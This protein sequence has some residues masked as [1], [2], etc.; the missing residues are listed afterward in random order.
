M[1]DTRGRRDD[2]LPASPV[3]RH[4][5]VPD[6][7]AVS[8][9]QG[10]RAT[11]PRRGPGAPPREWPGPV[12]RRL[13]DPLPDGYAPRFGRRARA[14][15]AEQAR[16]AEHAAHERAAREQTVQEQAARARRTARTGPGPAPQPRARPR[17]DDRSGPPSAPGPGTTVRVS[18][19]AGA[20]GDAAPGRSTWDDRDERA[21]DE[22]ELDP[23]LDPALEPELEAE[24][25]PALTPDVAGPLRGPEPAPLAAVR[26]KLGKALVPGE[27]VLVAQTRHPVVLAE[28]VLTSLLV[29][30]GIAAVSP[31]LG[32]MD[33][34]RNVLMAGWVAL[35]VRAL[36]AW[37]Q[38]SNDYFV[39][40]D[41]RLIRL[42]GLFDVQ[43]DMMP[44]TKVTDMA[45]ERPFWGRPFNYG[46]FVLESAGQ[47]QALRVIS[48]VRDPDN[49]D[50]IIGRQIFARPPFQ[51]PY[52]PPRR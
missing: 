24:L 52:P 30:L 17:D 29:L 35:A 1:A 40:T 51:S 50:A 25:D 49:V 2:D 19:R 14:E 28:P 48:F 43:R 44:L 18:G 46:R 38:W 4:G 22:L 26:R 36:W 13:R 45:F 23:A 47:D 12:L 34:V 3:V 39:V 5:R 31:Y 7:A 10:A 42:H 11:P 37:L 16:Q 15:K 21:D 27:R 20:A 41:R 9:V 33:I 32:A 8:P 6:P